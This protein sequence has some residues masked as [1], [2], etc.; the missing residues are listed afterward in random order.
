MSKKYQEPIISFQKY[1]EAD[2]ITAS[3]ATTPATD[4]FTK[5]P[6][7]DQTWREGV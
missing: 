3:D 1:E 6:Y 2:I 4:G 5:D 7:N